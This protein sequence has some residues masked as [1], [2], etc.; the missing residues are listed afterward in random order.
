MNTWS[1]N[2]VD[3]DWTFWTTWHF[4]VDDLDR[5]KSGPGRVAGSWIWVSRDTDD[6][7]EGVR[8]HISR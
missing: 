1:S 4:H 2:N 8:G 5:V 6:K 3:N 7:G